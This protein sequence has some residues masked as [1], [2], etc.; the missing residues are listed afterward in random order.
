MKAKEGQNPQH[1]GEPTESSNPQTPQRHNGGESAKTQGGRSLAQR[2][3]QMPWAS[4]PFSFMRRFSEDMDRLFE[5]FFGGHGL[6]WPWQESA[7]PGGETAWHPQLEILE[8]HNH[9]IVRADLP[10]LSAKDVSVEVEDGMLQ[11]SGERRQDHEEE[12]EGLRHCEVSYGRF[13]RAIPLPEGVDPE[14]A[15]ANF[16]NGVLEISF[17]KPK[18]EEHHHGRRIEVHSAEQTGAS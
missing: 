10:G 5:D 2:G 3:G 13:Y 4:S 1:K 8:R 9:L 7:A 16:R 11:I 14:G 6:T 18:Q 15:I 17:E 12:H